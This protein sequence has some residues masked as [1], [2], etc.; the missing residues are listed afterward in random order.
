MIKAT[1]GGGGKV[2]AA[3]FGRPKTQSGGSL[4]AKLQRW[5]RRSMY[6]LAY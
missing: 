5:Q 1:A 4:L 2:C 6:K 3:S